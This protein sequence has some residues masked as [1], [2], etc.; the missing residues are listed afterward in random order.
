MN[1]F[2][3]RNAL[4]ACG[5]AA[6]SSLAGC[7]ALSRDGSDTETPSYERLDVTPVYVADGTD[8]T[9][10]TEIETVDATN[11][12]DL[13]VLPDDTDTDAKQAVE[14]LIE[15]RVIALLG[16]RAE[17]PWLSWTRSDAFTDVFGHCQ[18]VPQSR[19]RL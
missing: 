15:D 16:E 1:Y 17:V 6:L 11:N 12:A 13:L 2:T 4:R 18:R 7:S 3:R 9:T 19:T 10:P 8:L 14:W 5:I